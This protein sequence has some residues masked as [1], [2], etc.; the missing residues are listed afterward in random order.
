MSPETKNRWVKYLGWG[1]TLGTSAVSL[2]S[3]HTADAISTILS[4]TL[5]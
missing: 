1:L 5:G 3:G 4:A 2:L